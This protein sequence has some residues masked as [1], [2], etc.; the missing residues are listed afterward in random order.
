M[1]DTEVVVVGAGIGGAVLALALARGGRSSVVLER[2]VAP[3]RIARPEVLWTPTLEAFDRLGGGPAIREQAAIP[4][5]AVEVLIVRDE[6]VTERVL[7][8]G[9]EPAGAERSRRWS[10]D[11]SRTREM[12]VEAALATGRVRLMRGVE[13]R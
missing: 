13:V 10:T 6:G 7:R 11:P 12:I 9:D 1:L 4:L 2:E 8:L 3:P 5:A